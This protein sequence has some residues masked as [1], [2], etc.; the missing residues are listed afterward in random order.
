MPVNIFGQAHAR[1]SWPGQVHGGQSRRGRLRLACASALAAALVAGGLSVALAPAA[2]AATGAGAGFWHTSG[3]QIL[4]ANNTPVRIA[5]INWYGFETKDEVIHGLWGQD[6]HDIID[7]IKRLGYNTIRMPF[8]NQ[9]V[10]SPII[11]GNIGWANGTKATNLD[12]QG[13]DSFQIMDKIIGYAGQVGLKVILDNHRS[14]GG[15]SAEDNGLWYTS[16]YPQNAWLADWATIAR[17]YAGNPTVIGYDLRNEPHTPTDLPYAQ[18]A[19]WGTGDTATDWRLAAQTAGNQLLAINPDALIFVEGIGQHPD[20]NGAM[21][22]TWWGGDLA[23]A[24]QYPV[25]LNVAN[26]L[27]YSPHDYGPRLYRQT[28]FNSSTTPAS[29]ATVWNQFWGYLYQQNT[30]PVL[31]GE[32]GTTNSASEI[33]SSEAGSQGQWFSAMIAYLKANPAMGWTYWALDG[34]DDFSL[35]DAQYNPTPISSAKQQLLASIQFPLPGAVNGSP[36][37]STSP[38]GTPSPSTPASPSTSPSRSPSPSASP[39]ASPSRSPSASPSATPSSSSSGGVAACRV[40]YA[41]QSEWP[42]GFV[43][44][45]TL[46]NTG[47]SPVNGW[48]LRFTFPGDQRITSAWNATV[49]ASGQAVTATNAGYNGTL[50]PGANTSFGFQGTWTASDAAPTA[51]TL[52]GVACTG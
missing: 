26:R 2:G 22:G 20:S 27:V 41:T 10:E 34:E 7:T 37:P 44:N 4:D 52:N 3:N 18:G 29:L 13:L 14:E 35:L 48:T 49:S 1:R 46:T 28:W 15:N 47:T 8:S 9:M 25:Q 42:G 19:T 17:R 36:S 40:S 21:V 31:V 43:A 12:L 39:S 32:F 23:M 11:P 24:A 5:G 16:A 38:S 6:Y 45:L 51:F 30:A 50:A 33:S